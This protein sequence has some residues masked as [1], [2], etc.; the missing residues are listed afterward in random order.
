MTGRLRHSARAAASIVGLLALIA[1]LHAASRFGLRGP[2]NWRADGIERWSEDPA[3]VAATALRWIALVFCYYLLAVAAAVTFLPDQVVD[4]GLSRVVPARVIAMF[5][6]LIGVAGVAG[7]A[8]PTSSTATSPEP[9]AA[10]SLSASEDPLSLEKLADSDSDALDALGDSHSLAPEEA[11]GED[12]D[13]VWTV[14]PGDHLWS[15]ATETLQDTWSRSELTDAEI[16]G[17]W[18]DVI[19]AN[20]DRLIEP[21]N[22]DLILPGQ[23]LLL[24]VAPE[25]PQ[26]A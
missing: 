22:P 5:S 16:A 13:S 21:G 11:T 20:Q 23:K 25:D 1:V 10:L 24:P 17:Y 3:T 19:D 18:R 4:R 12:P 14:V 26:A 6:I 8:G 2:E 9:E 15:I 7:V